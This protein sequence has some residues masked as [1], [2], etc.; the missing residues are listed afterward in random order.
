MHVL[1]IIIH[2]CS[3]FP[4][5]MLTNTQLSPG[6]TVLGTHPPWSPQTDRGIQGGIFRGYLGDIW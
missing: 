2:H 4:G 1:A 6:H 3:V 5:L